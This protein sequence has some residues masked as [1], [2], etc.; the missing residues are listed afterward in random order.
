MNPDLALGAAI[1]FITAVVCVPLA[2]LL[3]HRLGAIAMPRPDRWHRRPIPKLGGLAVSVGLVTG[4]LVMPVETADLVAFAAGVVALTVLG[5]ADDLRS[6]SPAVRLAI[7]AAVGVAFAAAISGGLD[8]GQTV[9]LVAV[10][11]LAVPIAANATNLVDNADGLAASLSLVSAAALGGIGL[12]GALHSPSGLLAIVIAASCLGFLLYNAPPARIFMGDS[13][14]LSI[15]FAL[16]ATFLMLLRDALT[17]GSLELVA[18]TLLAVVTIAPQVGDMAMVFFTRIGRGARPF[19]GD[20]DPTSH[21]LIA[22]GLGPWHTLLTIVVVAGVA[23][24][25]ISAAAVLSGEPVVTAATAV[26][27]AGSVAGLESLVAWHLPF[28]ASRAEERRSLV[29]LEHAGRRARSVRTSE[30]PL[31]R[32]EGR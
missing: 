14:S 20:V 30:A 13:G 16:A 9:A 23:A 32:L 2:G 8:T 22:A 3:A 21:R 1:A 5:L 17:S 12:L 19:R 26:L 15:G 27:V 31:E 11:F 4:A 7:E 28:E 25:A 24:A 10:A 29:A 18:V 6:V